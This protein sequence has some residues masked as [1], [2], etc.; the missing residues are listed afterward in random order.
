M[1]SMLSR[2]SVALNQTV[3]QVRDLAS[4]PQI[5]QNLLDTTRGF[6][7]TAT[8]IGEITQDLRHV[9][10]DPQT[11]AQLR[12]TIAN[13][14]AATQK[15]NSL[16]HSLGGT[17]SVYGVDAG[18]TPAPVRSGP[19]GAAAPAARAAAVPERVQRRPRAGS[20]QE[21]HRR[22]GSQSA[23]DSDPL[24][25]PRHVQS[26]FDRPAAAG[27]EQPRTANATSTR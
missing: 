13:T 11:Q 16:L 15:L 19:P 27:H 25:R 18:A 12:D 22:G 2:S 10:G 1:F 8:T 24:E 26:E 4:N 6:A 14:D 17:S 3:D 20:F 5:H 21:P 23:G 7:Q 9:T